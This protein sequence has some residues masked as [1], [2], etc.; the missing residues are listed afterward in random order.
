MTTRMTPLKAVAAGL[1]AALALA[2]GTALADEAGEAPEVAVPQQP[3]GEAAAPAAPETRR[4]LGTATPPSEPFTGEVARHDWQARRPW[5]YGTQQLYPLT[6]GMADA[7][8]PAWAR[9]P[10]YPF[11]VAFDT[12]NLVFGAIGGLFGD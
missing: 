6:R 11:T 9:W 10:L 1:G 7:G 8:I 2:A 5:G 3:G 12:G 4:E